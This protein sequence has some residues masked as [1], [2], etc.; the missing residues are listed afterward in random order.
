MKIQMQLPQFSRETTLLIVTAKQHSVFYLAFNGVLDKVGGLE[1]PHE[2]YSDR[3]G[4]FVSS[5]TGHTA[6]GAV[7]E[8]NKQE[9]IRKF[10]KK[11]VAE[12]ERLVRERKVDAIY[13][14]VPD[15]VAS[16]LKRDLPKSLKD[17]I[18][19]T[20]SGNHVDEHPFKL[21]E[22]IQAERF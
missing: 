16:E 11:T 1:E 9:V 19:H 4:F 15:Y 2:K 12:A 20:F 21:L 14:F 17:L 22:K 7:Y 18:R 10:A 8:E 13:L 5:G 6:S 3:E